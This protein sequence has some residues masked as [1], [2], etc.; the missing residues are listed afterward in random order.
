MTVQQKC[1]Y[2]KQY[3]DKGFLFVRDVIL[4][5]GRINPDIYDQLQD[6]RHYFRDMTVINKSLSPFR[7]L[8]YSQSLFEHIDEEY[9][10]D[11]LKSNYFYRKL[12]VQKQVLPKCI[13]YWSRQF[14]SALDINQFYVKKLKPLKDVK[15]KQFVYKILHNICVCNYLLNKWKISQTANC[16]YCE[17]NIH[18][19]KHMLWDCTHVRPL[20]NRVENVT[21][22]TLSYQDIIPGYNTW[23]RK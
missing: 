5:D 16:I 21:N 6:K 22:L 15:V 20:W 8:R 7:E 3:I 14:D 19:I 4:P 9:N 23:C 10:F 13:N 18:N 12:I 1:L 11:L 2:N 17:H